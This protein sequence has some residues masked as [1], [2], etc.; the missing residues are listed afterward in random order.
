[1][2]SPFFVARVAGRDSARPMIDGQTWPQMA[3]RV[4]TWPMATP[5]RT[6]CTPNIHPT[7]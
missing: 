4:A 3:Y 1:M 7:L 5:A 2:C 6:I